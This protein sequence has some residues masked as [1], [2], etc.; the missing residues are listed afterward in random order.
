[1]ADPY[2]TASHNWKVNRRPAGDPTNVLLL[3]LAV[4][5]GR[6]GCECGLNVS[7]WTEP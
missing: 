6:F 2:S 1:M 3:S 4:Q 7:S 5:G